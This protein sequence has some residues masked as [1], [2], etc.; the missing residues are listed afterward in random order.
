MRFVQNKDTQK[1]RTYLNEPGTQV[2]IPYSLIL[3]PSSLYYLEV[4]ANNTQVIGI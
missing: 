2:G 3:Q 4:R 1:Q